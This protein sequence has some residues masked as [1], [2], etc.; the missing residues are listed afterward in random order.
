M[1]N[2][3]QCPF[4]NK[5]RKGNKNPKLATLVLTLTEPDNWKCNLCFKENQKRGFPDINLT[6]PV[7]KQVND[8]RE[9]NLGV[10]MHESEKHEQFSSKFYTSDPEHLPVEKSSDRHFL[11]YLPEILAGTV[12][13]QKIPGRFGKAP[14]K[15]SEGVV[16]KSV[17][18]GNL[19]VPQQIVKDAYVEND[20][21]NSIIITRSCNIDLLFG[22]MKEMGLS[23]QKVLVQGSRFTMIKI[24]QNN[25]QFVALENYLQGRLHEIAVSYGLDP[26]LGFFPKSFNKKENYSHCGKIP[27]IDYFT[28][29]RPEKKEKQKALEEYI[30]SF[31]GLEWNFAKELIKYTSVK[32]MTLTKSVVE[33]VKQCFNIEEMLVEFLDLPQD[34]PLLHPFHSSVCSISSFSY[35]L[36][37][38]F[39][40]CK[41]G[42]VT[43]DNVENGV[44][45]ENASNAEY[46]FSMK[47]REKKPESDLHAAF[48]SGQGSFKAFR[49]VTVPDIY[50]KTEKALEIRHSCRGFFLFLQNISYW[51]IH[52]TSHELFQAWQLWDLAKLE[53]LTRLAS[54]FK[55]K[56]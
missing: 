4:L 3:H 34:T 48:L 51:K 47:V 11:G 32:C 53:P 5:T 54:L 30:A 22:A 18:G 44:Y 27:E 39:E 41:R 13:E 10:L 38:D 56:P 37:C 33:F 17:K 14:K 28:S 7:H 36:L 24:Q 8:T 43:V 25:V 29:I 46:L 9:A 2:G 12:T 52:F 31:D 26:P 42:L 1:E 45:T 19:T 21:A 16:L 35:K 50:D 55:N 6:C 15:F 49:H 40:L 20:L 23:P